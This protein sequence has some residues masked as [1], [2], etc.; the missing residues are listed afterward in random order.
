MLSRAAVPD[1]LS[2]GP[3][4]S[5]GFPGGKIFQNLQTQAPRFFGVKLGG[6]QVVPSNNRSKTDI[7]IFGFAQHTGAVGGRRVIAVY[8]IKFTA[9][10]NSRKQGMQLDERYAV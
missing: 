5:G 9:A 2:T 1:N 8:E 4:Q 7:G 3:G 6:R 10:F